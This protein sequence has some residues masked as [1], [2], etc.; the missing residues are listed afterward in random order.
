MFDWVNLFEHNFTGDY[1]PKD[2][3]VKKGRGTSP[4][5]FPYSTYRFILTANLP[6]FHRP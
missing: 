5:P 4:C 3:N 6:A 1:D 2:L